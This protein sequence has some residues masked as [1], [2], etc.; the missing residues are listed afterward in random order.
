MKT[1]LYESSVGAL[2]LLLGGNIF[3]TAD[4]YTYIL[5]SGTVLRYTNADIDITYS[6]NTWTS[7]SVIHDTSSTRTTGHWK[8]GL[9]VDSWQAVVVPRPKDPITGTLYPD[10]IDGQG[11][12]S[13]VR[14]G[15]L[16][17]ATVQ[18]DRAYAPA[19]PTDA[20]TFGKFI[21]TGI[22]TIFLGRV[23]AIDEDRLETTIT[24]ND[25]RELLTSLVP[26]NTWQAPCRH[27]LF[28]AGCGLVASSFKVSTACTAGSTKNVLLSAAAAGGS[29]TFQLG[30]IVMTSGAN[31]GRQRHVK[32]WVSGT[33]TLVAPLPFTVNTGDTFDA[34]PGCDKTITTCTAFSNLA[35]FGGMPFIPAP[36]T[37]I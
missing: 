37:A 13:A 2:D 35:N 29:G 22:L 31:I 24:L 15:A 7:R 26:R 6:G 11:W 4:L 18:V 1:I 33:F 23:A 27:V 14:G 36:E 17:G 25:M 10:Q 19:W 9:G 16:D 8:V 5:T 32:T 21:I 30:R 12:L 3:V 34:Y 20:A 28:D